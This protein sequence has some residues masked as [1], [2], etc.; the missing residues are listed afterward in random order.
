METIQL[1]LLALAAVLAVRSLYLKFFKKR[2]TVGQIAA[3]IKH[4]LSPQSPQPQS[5]YCPLN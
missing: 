3:A 4:S 1:L 2:M 5:G